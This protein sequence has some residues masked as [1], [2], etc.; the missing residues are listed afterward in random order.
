MEAE[1]WA[2]NW[3]SFEMTSGTP[4]PATSGNINT[5]APH[6]AE[7]PAQTALNLA[8]EIT[9]AP[10]RPPEEQYNELGPD[11]RRRGAITELPPNL[12][13]RGGG[14]EDDG[15][16]IQEQSESED[17]EGGVELGNLAHEGALAGES[18]DPEEEESWGP[19]GPWAEDQ[20]SIEKGAHQL[21][22]EELLSR[23]GH[24]LY[25]SVRRLT[26]R[27]F[28]RSVDGEISRP[29]SPKSTIE[30]QQSFVYV[31]E[32]VQTDPVTILEDTAAPADADAGPIDGSEN[33]AK[34]NQ[35]ER[36]DLVKQLQDV[37]ESCVKARLRE[38]IDRAKE[39][40]S[41]AGPIPKFTLSTDP[42]PETEY[43]ERDL[44][45]IPTAKSSDPL[46]VEN[47]TSQSQLDCPK[48]TARQSTEKFPLRGVDYWRNLAV[49]E[50]GDGNVRDNRPL[51]QMPNALAKE[52]AAA[53]EKHH[54]SDYAYDPD[55]V[56]FSNRK[57]KEIVSWMDDVEKR[58]VIATAGP[59]LHYP[60]PNAQTAPNYPPE[61]SGVQE[62]AA[63]PQPQ[64][65][66]TP[67]PYEQQMQAAYLY[68]QQ[69]HQLSMQQQRLYQQQ[70]QAAWMYRQRITAAALLTRTEAQGTG[71]TQEQSGAQ[72]EANAPVAAAQE[73]VASSHEAVAARELSEVPPEA[74]GLVAAAMQVLGY[75]LEPAIADP[76]V[77]AESE[78]FENS[79]E[80]ATGAQDQSDV[81]AG[82][83]ADAQAT[84]SH[85]QAQDS[86]EAV[87]VQ[88]QSGQA[89]DQTGSIQEQSGQPAEA[90]EQSGQ[91]PDQTGAIQEQS[92]QPVEAQEQSV[93]LAE[94]GIGAAPAA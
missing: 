83:E 14:L 30:P 54:P 55:N 31:N 32:G 81:L 49:A 58:Q 92:E 76:E 15:S 2:D 78:R 36:E 77:F 35:R 28:S 57:A 48:L 3:Q 73:Q 69:V 47:K 65:M 86:A 93:I 11:D 5:G 74:N 75:P 27:T 88:E 64:Q 26:R 9:E 63:A 59:S 33:C 94:A 7:I 53:G 56:P 12:R 90:R 62:Q 43:A 72:V 34:G 42:S 23:F 39:L 29:R 17:C 38:R 52:E 87:E 40:V 10:R 84:A 16:P 51:L 66:P 25:G 68:Q 85:G 22:A 89:T 21:S 50:P 4:G 13:I 79:H 67:T 91:A 82:A 6:L 70:M 18:R 1:P 60:I 71:Q 44:K 8:D 61:P 80:A 46:I 41:D 24:H 20:Q 19:W 37:D 45:A